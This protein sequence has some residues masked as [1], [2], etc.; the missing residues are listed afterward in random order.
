MSGEECILEDGYFVC[1]KK[2]GLKQA[3]IITAL[4]ADGASLEGDL[5][6]FSCLHGATV[7]E[8]IPASPAFIA[9]DSDGFTVTP[10]GWMPFCPVL[11]GAKGLMP[12]QRELLDM[13]GLD[14]SSQ[15]LSTD[16]ILQS[17]K[18][19][20]TVISQEKG[21][22]WTHISS[23]LPINNV[24][25][26]E[27]DALFTMFPHVPAGRQEEYVIYMINTLH[28]A[29]SVAL[30]EIK[31]SAS[32]RLTLGLMNNVIP[33]CEN[34]NVEA[35]QAVLVPYYSDHSVAAAT[36]LVDKRYIDLIENLPIHSMSTF[37]DIGELVP[38][39]PIPFMTQTCASDVYK[40]FPGGI[41]KVDDPKRI[42]ELCRALALGVPGKTT[43]ATGTMDP[44]K[45]NMTVPVDKDGISKPG[46]DVATFICLATLYTAHVATGEEL[47]A[48]EPRHLH[49]MNMLERMHTLRDNE[50]CEGNMKWQ[51]R[52]LIDDVHAATL[53]MYIDTGAAIHRFEYE[54]LAVGKPEE[55]KGLREFVS[56]TY[57]RPIVALPNVDPLVR[58]WVATGG[59][60]VMYAALV[61]AME[62]DVWRCRGENSVGSRM[63][64]P[65]QCSCETRTTCIHSIIF[66]WCKYTKI[67]QAGTSVNSTTRAYS[68]ARDGIQKRSFLKRTASGAIKESEKR[69]HDS[70]FLGTMR[71]ASGY[72]ITCSPVGTA[73]LSPQESTPAANEMANDMKESKKKSQS[74]ASIINSIVKKVSMG[75]EIENMELYEKGMAAGIT[76]MKT[77]MAANGEKQMHNTMFGKSPHIAFQNGEASWNPG[78]RNPIYTIKHGRMIKDNRSEMT[79]V[80]KE[81][82]DAW[83]NKII[84]IM[85]TARKECLEIK[86]KSTSPL[87]VEMMWKNLLR[88]DPNLNQ[89]DAM[90]APHLAATM[91]NL[92]RPAV[93][94]QKAVGLLF[95]QTGFTKEFPYFDRTKLDDIFGEGGNL[96]YGM[97]GK[98]QPQ[99]QD[100]S[101][102]T[103]T[104]PPALV[105][106]KWMG[107]FNQRMSIATCRVKGI[108]KG[109]DVD[110]KAKIKSQFGQAEIC[111]DLQ[112]Q[113]TD[114]SIPEEDSDVEN[115]GLLSTPFVFE[116]DEDDE[117]AYEFALRDMDNVATENEKFE[118]TG[119]MRGKLLSAIYGIL[120]KNNN[121]LKVI[122][123]APQIIDSMPKFRYMCKIMD[124]LYEMYSPTGYFIPGNDMALGHFKYIVVYLAVCRM[125]NA[126]T[127]HAKPIYTMCVFAGTCIK[128]IGRAMNSM[129]TYD[130]LCAQDAP[131]I[132]TAMDYTMY[133]NHMQ[134]KVYGGACMT[135]H[136]YAQSSITSSIL[137][138][139]N[140]RKPPFCVLLA[141]C[142][143]YPDR[144]REDMTI[145]MLNGM[146]FERIVNDMDSDKMANIIAR[147][148]GYENICSAASAE[149]SE[150]V[151]KLLGCLTVSPDQAKI[152]VCLLQAKTNNSE[153][154][155]E[156]DDE[157]WD[158]VEVCDQ[159]T[160]NDINLEPTG[161]A[162]NVEERIQNYQ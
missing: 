143:P 136:H 69:P 17:A 23:V 162:I 61:R 146:S 46:T 115:K 74:L 93:N 91:L 90:N 42:L 25:K 54:N 64:T 53:Y 87:T 96:Q 135:R 97:N 55:R 121:M 150:L 157:T 2:D 95:P 104:N 26:E 113:T 13:G 43:T 109:K 105:A 16:E 30:K 159:E 158:E 10:G 84:A 114:K 67:N 28:G 32:R 6:K 12:D 79:T 149:A 72:D 45:Y 3:E 142:I 59:D 62:R 19:A 65:M 129:L 153:E 51:L 89:Y 52:K 36:R 119:W 133:G 8:K 127:V 94:A 99:D 15:I 140:V 88:C 100:I 81:A 160:E 131:Y 49:I 138:S 137:T 134:A 35:L 77:T 98:F 70:M 82:A 14:K 86:N 38:V 125:F 118:P 50:Q 40:M 18:D 154:E 141:P 76:A 152:I 122:K 117:T 44:H 48:C 139:A 41:H 108:C 11:Y 34:V 128:G 124:L 57:Q 106:C 126:P 155:H 92:L 66:E 85:L 107:P 20:K 73:T 120:V 47:R 7:P 60:F 151:D 4:L 145:G 132:N 148:C 78:N 161:K 83:M 116:M 123:A 29:A 71:V 21:K 37:K 101:V 27:A 130:L 112:Q 1:V 68:S 110:Y 147:A 75:T 9:K 144:N 56:K 102:F 58:L 156:M 33:H 39:P 103:H 80:I 5:G 111:P 31:R 63:D 24:S 22:R